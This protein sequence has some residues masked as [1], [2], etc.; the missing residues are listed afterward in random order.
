MGQVRLNFYPA[1]LRGMPQFMKANKPLHPIHI[2]PFR[3]KRSMPQPHLSTQPVQPPSPQPTLPNSCHPRRRHSMSLRVEDA[4][5]S[6]E[7]A[8]KSDTVG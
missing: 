5:G 4:G 1:H 6:R 3:R 7:L 8:T 2:G